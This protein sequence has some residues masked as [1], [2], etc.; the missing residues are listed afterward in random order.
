MKLTPTQYELIDHRLSLGAELFVEVLMDHA[1]EPPWTEAEV[2]SAWEAVNQQVARRV[3]TLEKLTPCELEIF[4]D[5]L[6]GSTFFCDREDAVALY[7]LGT[8]ELRAKVK[9][10]LYLTEGKPHGYSRSKL[11]TMNKAADELQAEILRATGRR[12]T[13]QRS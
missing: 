12:C 10:P 9:R 11:R 8:A 6:E 13:T 2:S 5:C 4:C 3:V 7:E 1:E